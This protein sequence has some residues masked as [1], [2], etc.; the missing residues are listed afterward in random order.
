MFFTSS[1]VKKA[2]V[3]RRQ[4]ARQFGVEVMEID[5]S[6]CLKWSFEMTRAIAR[7]LSKTNY[8]K[9][10]VKSVKGDEMEIE[11]D[12]QIN[13]GTGGY[14]RTCKIYQIRGKRRKLLQERVISQWDILD[15]SEFFLLREP[16][17]GESAQR[18]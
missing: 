5:W 14:V 10:L 3:L 17:Q 7:K 6:E 4:A 18:Q 11:C 2:W 1:L 12:G 16:I 15:L 8:Q 13:A 9:I